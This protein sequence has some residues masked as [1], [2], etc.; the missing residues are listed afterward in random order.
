MLRTLDIRN[1]AI[2][3]A[4]HLEFDNNLNII[5]GETGAGKSILMGA[6]GLVLGKRA[7]TTVLRDKEQ[8]CTVEAT[9]DISAYSLQPF[10]AENDLDYEEQTLIRREIIPSGKSRAF[11]NDVPVT[12]DI[13]QSLT[14]QLVDIHAQQETQQLLRPEF[15]L[16]ILDSIAGQQEEVSLYSEGFRQLR[17]KEARHRQ[18]KE[19]AERARQEEDFLRFQY[20][21]LE[22]AALDDPGLATIEQ[23]LELLENAEAVK[24]AMAQARNML[25]DSEISVSNQIREL[26][27]LLQPL[28]HFSDDIAGSKATLEE[29][30]LQ[31]R[32]MMRTLDHVA[33]S[34]DHQ[35]ERIQLLTERQNALNRLLQ[36]HQL[37]DI[38]A[39]QTLRDHIAER[40][41]NMQQATEQID[42]LYLEIEQLKEDCFKKAQAIS[43]RRRELIPSLSATVS[44]I[45]Q[46]LG[47]PYATVH[48]D[49]PLR[50]P[51]A[52]TATGIDDI[53]LYFSPNKGST[54]Q[55][56]DRIGSGGEKSR[57]MLAIKSIVA[58]SMALPTLIFDE[59][60]TG[61]SGAIAGKMGDILLKLS[62]HHQVIAITHLPQVAA[63]GHRHY[64]VYKQHDKAMTYTEIRALKGEERIL[65]IAK[66]LSGDNP[67]NAALQT[68]REL[69]G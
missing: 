55:T 33:D 50:P 69:I 22:A 36:K 15:Y 56:L 66:M 13:L 23:E 41:G 8:K 57:L 54:P 40:L 52:L 68:A 14:Q 67:G 53:D 4:I 26:I 38:A 9:F 48:W 59:I 45:L 2:I 44:G 37:T 19:E 32:E 28:A 17:Q 5:T 60:D 16:K 64:F 47:M 3:E 21:E 43:S 6:L 46:E 58:D 61:V 42:A 29:W 35:P 20:D 34:S 65:E 10:F 51:E 18:L 39:L 63:R 49:G 11:V 7:D 12:L 1:F 30:L 24:S 25:E 62:A 31:A 27:R